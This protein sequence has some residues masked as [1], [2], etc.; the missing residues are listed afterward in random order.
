MVSVPSLLRRTANARLRFRRHGP[1][2]ESL[3][4]DVAQRSADCVPGQT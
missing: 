1:R 3:Q 2:A 4:E